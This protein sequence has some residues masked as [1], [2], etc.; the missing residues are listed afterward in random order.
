M[1]RR[2][3]VMYLLSVVLL[4]SAVLGLFSVSY[5]EE[6]GSIRVHYLESEA[7]S[8]V[9]FKLYRVAD[10]EDGVVSVV[11]PFSSYGISWDALEDSD[12]NPLAMTLKAYIVRDGIS[13]IQTKYT[14]NDFEC[15]FE[16]L[17]NGLYLVVGT[18][19]EQNDVL[20]TPTPFFVLLPT[21]LNG[22]PEY[23]VVT[24]P[25]GSILGASD[26][27]KRKVLKVWK[28][29]TLSQR[30][31]RITV[32]LLKDGVVVDTVEL[33]K[34]NNWRYSWENLS[35]KCEWLVVERDVPSNYTTLIQREGI[36]FVVTNTRKNGGTKT[37][38]T[39]TTDGADVFVSTTTTTTTTSEPK[40]VEL[41]DDVPKGGAD[42]EE[43]TTIV[44]E[45]PSSEDLVELGDLVPLAGGI[46]KTGVLWWPVPVLMCVGIL[47]LIV[48][49]VK[50]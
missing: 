3:S 41:T 22:V 28:K 40:T 1:N 37:T 42:P 44:V 17:T 21:T 16:G 35:A 24:N 26:T 36:T 33:S 18:A 43:T 49:L 23:D 29:D 27:L 46:P 30:P 13:S 15:L 12:W 32:D 48:G 2:K 34:E 7:I 38:T 20:Y 45:Q 14:N 39:T 4:L 47:F 9:E 11:P 50:K 6:A 25:K 10:Y 8:N 31:T 19:I 5:A